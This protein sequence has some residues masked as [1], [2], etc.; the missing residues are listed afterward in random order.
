[1]D[2]FE[3]FPNGIISE[4]FE[5]GV[6]EF[7]T[8]VGTVFSDAKLCDVVVD[9]GTYTTTGRAPDTPYMDSGIL[10]Y[11]KPEQMPTLVT[12]KLTNGYMWHDKI[13]DLYYEVREASLGKNQETGVVEHIEFLLRPTE[14][15]IGG[16]D[17]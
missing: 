6:A 13:N 12:A 8:E 11:A 10:L 9:E 4:Q 3:A 5:L 2:I 1:M 14:V 16:E 15:A 7:G 17:E